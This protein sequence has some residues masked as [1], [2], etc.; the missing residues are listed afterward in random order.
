MALRLRA[1]DH[2]DQRRDVLG[3]G[4]GRGAVVRLGQGGVV[5]G[6]DRVEVE[7]VAAA[8]RALEPLEHRRQVLAR[9]LVGVGHRDPVAIVPDRDDRRP[10]EHADGVDALPEQPFGAGGIADGAPG[11]LA[12]A[13]RERRQAGQRRQLAIEARGIRQPDEARHLGAGR[14]DVRRRVGH[15]REVAPATVAVKRPRAEVGVHHAAGRR[16]VGL[17]VGVG[18]QLGEELVDG[19]HAEREDQ[20]LVAVVA[21]ADV[22][23][24]EEPGQG[25]LRHFLAIAEDA[26]LRLAAHHLA[27]SDQAGLAALVRQPVVADDVLGGDAEVCERRGTTLDLCHVGTTP[28]RR[29]CGR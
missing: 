7:P 3:A 18:V 1:L 23:R 21:G 13:A 6:A 26:E 10:A 19:A 22:P 24:R 8:W 15:R 11:D 20:G 28:C 17:G 27:P 14:R 9:D 2:V 25:H 4:R 29:R 12:A 16:G 5:P